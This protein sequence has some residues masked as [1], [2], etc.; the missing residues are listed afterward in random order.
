MLLRIIITAVILLVPNKS[1]VAADEVSDILSGLKQRYGSL[2]G[3]S[4]PYTREIIS[5]TIS[6]LPGKM[7]GD[8]AS[9]TLHFKPPYS[10]RLDQDKPDHE[11]LVSDGDKIWWHV[12]S[13][14]M[15]N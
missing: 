13:K 15:V 2:P 5:R 9:G 6:M 11:T 10:L 7:R 8:V 4:V 12:P 14:N 1:V 3:M